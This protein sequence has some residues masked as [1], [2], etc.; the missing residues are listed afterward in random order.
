MGDQEI[1]FP[2]GTVFGGAS[3]DQAAAL[4]EILVESHN[5]HMAEFGLM[6][7]KNKETAQQVVSILEALSK[8]QG[9]GEI[10]IFFNLGSNVIQNPSL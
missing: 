3:K 6:A 9:T 7:E 4:A 2:N 10:T 8:S 5:K 1:V